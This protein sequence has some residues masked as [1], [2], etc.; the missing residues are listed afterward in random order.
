MAEAG[1]TSLLPGLMSRP[2][3]VN[4]S[5]CVDEQWYFVDG[6]GAADCDRHVGRRRG[7][8]TVPQQTAPQPELKG[9]H[10]PEPQLWLKDER[11][12]TQPWTQAQS[13]PQ[14]QAWAETQT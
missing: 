12:L 4:D 6:S 9:E 14:T 10:E 8:Q 11:H 1:S 3:E 13:Q 5:D 7:M 2:V